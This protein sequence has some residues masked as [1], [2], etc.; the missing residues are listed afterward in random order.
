MY[1]YVFILRAY[2]YKH[3]PYPCPHVY[4]KYTLDHSW[5]FA[6]KVDNRFIL[7]ELALTRLGNLLYNMYIFYESLLFSRDFHAS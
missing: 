6:F 4:Y 5:G 3:V 1:T 2:P 7:Q